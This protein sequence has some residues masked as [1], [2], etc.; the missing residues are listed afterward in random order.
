MRWISVGSFGRSSSVKASGLT[1]RQFWPKIHCWCWPQTHEGIG[2]SCG[3]EKLLQGAHHTPGW[4]MNGHRMDFEKIVKW[5]YEVFT[6]ILF[7][8]A[9]SDCLEAEFEWP[10]KSWTGKSPFLWCSFPGWGETAA[11]ILRLWGLINKSI[12]AIK[13]NGI[14]VIL[15]ILPREVEKGLST[16]SSWQL[17][18]KKPQEN[19]GKP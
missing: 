10:G 11:L 5:F 1:S 14:K 15:L 9:S 17:L 19:Q 4:A 8:A 2:W 18:H 12:C 13:V 7:S 3:L 6:T 16:L